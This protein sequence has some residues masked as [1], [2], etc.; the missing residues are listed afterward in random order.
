MN[1][2]DPKMGTPF[3]FCDDIVDILDCFKKR[4]FQISFAYLIAYD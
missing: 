2:Y 1:F 3:L 4:Y